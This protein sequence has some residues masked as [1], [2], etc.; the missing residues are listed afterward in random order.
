MIEKFDTPELLEDAGFQVFPQETLKDSDLFWHYMRKIDKLTQKNEFIAKRPPR[1]YQAE[2]ASIMACRAQNFPIWD[3]GVGKSFL[4][5][6]L[7]HLWYGDSLEAGLKFRGEK[8]EDSKNWTKTAPLRPGAIQ[9]VAPRHTL[10]LTWLDKELKQSGLAEYAEI[11]SSEEDIVSSQKPIWLYSYDLLSRQTRAGKDMLKYNK[12]EKDEAHKKGMRKRGQ[13]YYFMG[14]PISKL[15]AKEYAPKFLIADEIHRLRAGTDRTRSFKHI[16]KKARRKLGM[17]GTP[18][19]GWVE[20]IATVLGITYGLQSKAFPF[21][22]ESFTKRF[23][24]VKM[25]NQDWS[26]GAEDHVAKERQVPGVNPAQL[27]EF[28]K[29]TRH[30]MHRLMIRDPEVNG[31]VQFPPVTLHECSIPM[32]PD[33]YRYYNKIRKEQQHAI[34]ETIEQ[35]ERG[36]I[37]AF[38]GKKTVLG[39]I[40]N[41][42]MASNMPWAVHFTDSLNQ[43]TSK[44][45]KIVEICLDAK[46]QDRKVIVFTSFIKTGGRIVKELQKAGLGVVRVY[47]DDETANPRKMT[48]SMRD[49]QIELFQEDPEITVLVANLALI[50]EGLTL[51]EASVIINHD[52]PWRSVLRSQGISRVVR[53]GGRMEGVDVYELVHEHTVDAYIWDMVK[54]KDAAN[55]ALI[56]RDVTGLVPESDLDEMYV[57][58]KLIEDLTHV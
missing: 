4:A 44:I 6:L 29:S 1:K 9:I 27:P 42:R 57:A 10:R 28:Y 18:M 39:Q 55:K 7:I 54:A 47:A 15:I 30:L 41:L 38:K 22:E 51:T 33:H 3:M 17:T 11:I 37:S 58:Q 13:S 53:P 8:P 40:Q 5:C 49:E 43:S 46:K 24:R 26:T 12:T 32:T 20:H 52:H 35:M 21:S 16:S 14:K 48:P 19:D 25:V 50:S 34:Q 45:N 2:Y 31:Q 23:T 56:D 36:E